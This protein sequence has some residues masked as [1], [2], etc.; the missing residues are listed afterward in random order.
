MTLLLNK[1]QKR[2]RAKHGTPAAFAKACYESVPGFISMD[3]AREAV[4]N[5]NAE[6]N[7]AL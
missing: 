3:E 6:W 7:N 1:A 4:E 2:L 5:Y